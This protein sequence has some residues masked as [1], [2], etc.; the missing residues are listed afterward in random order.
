MGE[1]DPAG[2]HLPR[3][4]LPLQAIG[5]YEAVCR[6]LWFWSAACDQSC[7]SGLVISG[8]VVDE[9]AGMAGGEAEELLIRG[10][11]RKHPIFAVDS[12]NRDG[13]APEDLLD[14]VVGAGLDVVYVSV[15]AGIEMSLI[16]PVH[17]REVPDPGTRRHPNRLCRSSPGPLRVGEVWLRFS[18]CAGAGASS[19]P[20][21]SSTSAPTSCSAE[22]RSAGSIPAGSYETAPHT[23]VQPK[24]NR[25]PAA[26][27]GPRARCRV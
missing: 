13:P 17:G 10:R 19:Q 26:C 4:A 3:G 18:T 22:T 5:R 1:E 8:V 15:W 25:A 7:L 16:V 20:D 2:G 9:G 6:L 21:R 12:G 14:R 11:R 24:M 23:Y 27:W